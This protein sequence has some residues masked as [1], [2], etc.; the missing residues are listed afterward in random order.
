M[1]NGMSAGTKAS[2]L[3]RTIIEPGSKPAGAINPKAGCLVVIYGDELGRRI[4]LGS[5]PMVIGR[6]SKCDIPID[7]ES[8][9]RDHCRISHDGQ[10]YLARDLGS[11]NGTYVNDQLIEEMGLRSG[12]QLKVGR[13]ILK[14]ILGDDV[15]A[16]YHEEIYRLMTTDGL[17]QLSNKRHFDD[18]LEREVARA[19]RYKRFFSLLVFDL[20]HFKNIN[21]TYGHL[22]GDSILRQLGGV[23]RGRI[24]QNDVLARI[25][26]EEFALITPEVQGP[27]ALELGEKINALVRD[28]RFEFDGQQLQVT[29][30]VGVAEWQGHYDGAGELLAAADEKLY[31][32]KHL[33]RDRVAY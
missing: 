25:G 19:K 4:P 12:D 13:T 27:G 22:A 32:A 26:G 8:I 31:E 11:T 1:K 16:Q 7:Q 18:M 30:S 28:T 29:V 6:S 3:K 17:T 9:S 20:D 21:D 33:G 23:L 5:E 2:D 14:F 15:E 24:R 10:R